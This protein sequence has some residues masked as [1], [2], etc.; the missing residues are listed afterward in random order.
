MVSKTELSTGLEPRLQFIMLS[1]T[2]HQWGR[3]AD[4]FLLLI[5]P[6]VW[7][8]KPSCGYCVAFPENH[9]RFL[10]P[11]I[12]QVLDESLHLFVLQSVHV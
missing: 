3:G 9:M 11:H 5:D 10:V 8:K 6:L 12:P 4:S 1:K 2:I 7:L